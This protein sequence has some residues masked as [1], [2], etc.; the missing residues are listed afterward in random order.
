MKGRIKRL[1]VKIKAFEYTINFLEQAAKPILKHLRTRKQVRMSMLS[2]VKK[3][4][5]MQAH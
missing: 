4:S 3:E 2:K 1:L 5:Q